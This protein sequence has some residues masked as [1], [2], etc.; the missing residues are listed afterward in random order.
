MATPIRVRIRAPNS[1]D[2][3]RDIVGVLPSGAT[4]EDLS[5]LLAAHHPAK[6]EPGRLKL[7]ASGRLLKTGAI[8][9]E[10]G[11]VRAL[12]GR[13][14]ETIGVPAVSRCHHV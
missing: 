8:A 1:D 5:A 12:R 11:N 7:I 10:L 6:P 14:R 13:A 3:S 9:T 4:V 2:A